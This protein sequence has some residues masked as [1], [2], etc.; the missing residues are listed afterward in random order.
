MFD[1]HWHPIQFNRFHIFGWVLWA[2]R[3]IDG[4]V[5]VDDSEAAVQRHVDGHLRLSHLQQDRRRSAT[6]RRRARVS[7]RA[8][9]G[10]RRTVSMGDETNGRCVL[11]FLVTCVPRLTS[12]A[13]KSMWP[14]RMM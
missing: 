12:T 10:R 13:S 8:A 7:G 11:I 2:R 14:G 3:T 5:A 4:V 6:R 9:R 1:M